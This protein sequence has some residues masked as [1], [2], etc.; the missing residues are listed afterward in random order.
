MRYRIEIADGPVCAEG[1]GTLVAFD[2]EAER[3]VEI[4][5]EWREKLRQFEELA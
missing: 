1:S 4:P 2:Y 5:P 3:A